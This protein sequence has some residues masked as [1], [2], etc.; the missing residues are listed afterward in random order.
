M[1]YYLAG[2]IWHD[3]TDGMDWRLKAKQKLEEMG[4][5]AVLPQDKEKEGEMNREAIIE[6]R[7]HFGFMSEMSKSICNRIVHADFLLIRDCQGIIA[8]L[9]KEACSPGTYMEII[10]ASR[11]MNRHIIIIS[12]VKDPIT[13]VSAFLEAF[14]DQWFDSWQ[15]FYKELSLVQE[16]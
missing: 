15:S 6:A 12:D 14:A 2:P 5:E 3:K 8:Y 16:L 1:K 10:E 4:H 13:G 9:P 7:T 11:H